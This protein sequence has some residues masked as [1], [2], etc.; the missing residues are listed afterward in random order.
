MSPLVTRRLFSPLG[1]LVGFWL[2]SGAQWAV[3]ARY[4]VEESGLF[5]LLWLWGTSLLVVWWVQADARQTGYR[6]C[7]EYGAFMFFGWPLLLPHYLLRTRGIRGFSWIGFFFL[8]F[9]LPWLLAI[10]VFYLAG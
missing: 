5:H 9:C 6:P 2:L 7:Y 8:I 10:A 4:G 1:Q 3:Y